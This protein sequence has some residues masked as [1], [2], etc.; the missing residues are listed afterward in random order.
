MNTSDLYKNTGKIALASKLSLQTRKKMYSMFNE[1]IKPA[2]SH[3]V[4]DIGVTSDDQYPESNYFEKMYPYKDNIVCV[5]TEDGSFLEEKYPGIRYIKVYAGDPLPFV[6]KEFDIA[7][8]NAVIEHVGGLREQAAFVREIIRVSKSFF[9]TTPNRWF[10]VE[11]HTAIPLLHWLPKPL[12][13]RILQSIGE[14]YWS[15]EENLNILSMK[16]FS[17]LFP[18]EVRI[19]RNSVS[20]FGFP[21]NLIIYG[22]SG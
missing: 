16:E 11:F 6:D 1:V 14:L 8:S 20:L 18:G 13:R 5:G 12:H 19:V 2:P 7:F 17:S 9:I 4:L 10:P 22:T 21:T 15:K 3:K